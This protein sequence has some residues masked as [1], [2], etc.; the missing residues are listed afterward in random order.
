MTISEVMKKAAEHGVSYGKYVKEYL[1]EEKDK[2]EREPVEGK[3]ICRACGKEISGR[4]RR[5]VYCLEC[6][7]EVTRGLAREYGARARLK[8]AKEGGRE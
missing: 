5:A 3:K 8:R 7:G 2:S 6:A 4:N 1:P